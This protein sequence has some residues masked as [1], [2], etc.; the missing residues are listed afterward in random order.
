M[1][2]NK[3]KNLRHV[4]N[5]DIYVCIIKHCNSCKDFENCKEYEEESK[6]E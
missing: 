3:C 1:K 6:D 4:T 5:M 2:K